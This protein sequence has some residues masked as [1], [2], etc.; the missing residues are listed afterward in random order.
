MQVFQL[1]RRKFSIALSKINSILNYSVA[2]IVSVIS[3]ILWIPFITR[4]LSKEEFGYF[5]YLN[6]TFFLLSTILLIGT[7]YIQ[8]HPN[9]EIGNKKVIGLVNFILIIL[10]SILLIFIL[11]INVLHV[12]VL[13]ILLYTYASFQNNMVVLNIKKLS[14][15][16]SKYQNVYSLL[17]IL[18]SIT[19]IFFFPKAIY[20][21]IGMILALMIVNKLIGKNIIDE[22]KMPKNKNNF[23]LVKNIIKVG[24]PLVIFSFLFTAY[25]YID[26]LF[27]NYLTN[28]STVGLYNSYF[29]LIISIFSIP[30][31]IVTLYL[32]PKYR[33]RELKASKINSLYITLII[34][35]FLLFLLCIIFYYIG[36]LVFKIL[37]PDEYFIDKIT[38]IL[39]VITAFLLN[40]LKQFSIYF[41]F[42]LLNL[43]PIFLLGL[44][45]TIFVK[46]ILLLNFNV[47][48][49][50]IVNVNNLVLSLL[51]ISLMIFI[52]ITNKDTRGAK[53]L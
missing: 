31:T 23:D 18:F 44:V 33:E 40:V 27:L 41:Q 21:F 14:A 32:L 1:L 42:T 53:E 4:I 20:L 10:I 52:L 30:M 37:L 46:T 17:K 51:N 24:L 43:Y 13:A 2:T 7:Y 3:G 45:L 50:A 28:N 34:N 12:L 6:Q 8:T 39:L 26:I 36:E 25:T 48:I 35:T 11:R 9:Y 29:S 49:L 22:Q 5:S 19:I 15:Q 47:S 38:I 16:Y